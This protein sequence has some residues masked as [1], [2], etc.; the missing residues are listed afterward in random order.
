MNIFT[1]SACPVQSALWLDDKRLVKMILESA[2]ILSTVVWRYKG[3]SNDRSVHS[4]LYKATHTGHPCILWSGRTRANFNWLVDHAL[5]MCVVYNSYSGKTHASQS[6]INQAKEFKSSVPKGGLQE[7][8]NATPFKGYK[9]DHLDIHKKYQKFMIFKWSE[10]D[11]TSPKWTN[12]K[13][14][15]WY[16][17]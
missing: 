7:F 10:L 13:Q 12:R 6:V 1:T 15:E 14:P 2:Q 8:A 17:V 11:K 5:A 9:F 16:D 3:N 4:G